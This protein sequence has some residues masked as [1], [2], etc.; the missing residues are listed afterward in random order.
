MT[1]DADDL[2]DEMDLA[3]SEYLHSFTFRL[4]GRE[5]VFLQ[6]IDHALE[7][8]KEGNF[9]VC[10][11]CGEPISHEAPR[12]AARDD[13]V[14][15]L[16]GRPGADREGLRLERDPERVPPSTPRW[17]PPGGARRD[18]TRSERA[19]LGGA[20]AP[21]RVLAEPLP[22]STGLAS[23]SWRGAAG[24]CAGPLAV[25]F[26]S[27]SLGTH[28]DGTLR[29]PVTLPFDGDGY[30]VPAPW[31]PRH[32]N[33]GTE[34]LVGAVVRAARVVDRELPGGVAAIGDLSHRAGGG[35]AQHR[36]HQ[37]GR[38]VDVFYYAVDRGGRPVRPGDAML[39]FSPDGRA[40]RWSPPK[41]VRAPAA[42]V[43]DDRFDAHRNWAFVRALLVRS[44]ASRCSGSS[45]SG[46]SRRRC[47]REATRGGRRSG[48]RGAGR[49]HHARAERLG[50]AR[51]S[52][53][54]P[55]LL[56]ARRSAARLRRPGA[57]ALVEEDVEVHAGA[58]RAAAR[59]RDRRGG[60][61]G[62]RP[63]ASAASCRRSSSAARRPA[64]AQADREAPRAT[65]GRRPRARLT[66]RRRALSSGRTGS[67]GAR[68]ATTQSKGGP[69]AAS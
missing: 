56:R 29:H 40:T 62:A 39:H 19:S 51:R 21:P 10:E 4:R 58:V 12:G 37:S 66:V 13:A 8:I 50:A 6:K 65:V 2:P 22:R 5:K 35:S 55:A 33:Y 27:A 57:R 24:G 1:L 7:K 52:H 9:G 32:A 36:S 15:P 30:T 63:A 49:V 41:G 3:S 11:Q 31:R 34:E 23:C 20:R 25:D 14:H 18:P 53:A 45:C 42:P 48:A 28:A 47:S 60:R 26:A 38:D 17:V 43:P 69:A 59:R 54:R 67:P 61:R 68:C 46:G 64:D 16:Q 44:G